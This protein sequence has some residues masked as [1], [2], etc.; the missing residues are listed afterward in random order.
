MAI[1]TLEEVKTYL[2]ITWSSEDTLLNSLLSSTEETILKM[3]WVSSL[4]ESE[5]TE[6]HTYKKQPYI[7]RWICPHWVVKVNSTPLENYDLS[8]F[9]LRFSDLVSPNDW[10]KINISYMD[11]YATIPSD[12]K[13]AQLQMISEERIVSKSKWVTEFRQWDLSVKYGS[14]RGDNSPDISIILSKYKR[15]F[16]CS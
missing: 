2:G 11:G 9:Q 14:P 7:L 16:I 10:W 12:I 5:V 6:K 8:W 1:C 13:L 3:L 4:I 15:V